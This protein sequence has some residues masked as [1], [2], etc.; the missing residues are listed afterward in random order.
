MAKP[1]PMTRMASVTARSSR[2]RLPLPPALP[3]GLPSVGALFSGSMV[4]VVSGIQRCRRQLLWQEAT[5][6]GLR[7]VNRQIERSGLQLCFQTA[8]RQQLRFSA[9]HLQVISQAFPKAQYRQIVGFLRSRQRLAL[10]GALPPQ[11][12]H[13]RERIDDFAQ[14]IGNDLVVLL[15]GLIVLRVL[16]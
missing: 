8:L 14:G 15:D 4:T 16:R 11:A 2:L 6:Q 12:V 9:Q 5:A 13:G 3:S 7:Q 1:I 10:L